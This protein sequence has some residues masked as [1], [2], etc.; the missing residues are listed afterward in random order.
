M[1][2]S[3]RVVLVGS[4][5]S[6]ASVSAFDPCPQ[7]QVCLGNET[8]FTCCKYEHCSSQW[9][10]FS[11]ANERS[12]DILTPPA[13]ALETRRSALATPGLFPQH[14]PKGVNETYGYPDG[15]GALIVEGPFPYKN[16][17]SVWSD[18]NR[19][20]AYGLIDIPG[21][22]SKDKQCP[23]I[24]KDSPFYGSTDVRAI[25]LTEKGANFCLLGCDLKKVETTGVDP[26][27]P[28]S[29]TGGSPTNSPMSCW[30][31]G[32]GFAGGFGVCG[33]NCSALLPKLVDGKITPCSKANVTSGNCNI[34]CDTREFPKD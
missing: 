29:V 16:G 19:W 21:V 18:D 26:C 17:P 24:P 11:C 13:P 9:S 30:D 20:G 15:V 2:T 5:F 32:P 31:V 8:T 34:F 3:L 10:N 4:F 25:P 22:P 1:P 28:G 27:K 12:S 23:P 14:F 33:Y 6:S 7:S